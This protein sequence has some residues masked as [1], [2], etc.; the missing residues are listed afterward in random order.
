MQDPEELAMILIEEGYPIEKYQQIQQHR[1]ARLRKFEQIGI[2]A[3]IDKELEIIAHGERVL[4]IM[5]E[6]KKPKQE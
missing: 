3:L 6:I 1:Y 5:K 2:P 4:E